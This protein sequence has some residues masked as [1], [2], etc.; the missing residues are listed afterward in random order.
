MVPPSVRASHAV[1]VLVM[2]L[3]STDTS[4]E[5]G[6]N[7]VVLNTRRSDAARCAS[8]YEPSGSTLSVLLPPT[9]CAVVSCRVIAAPLCMLRLPATPIS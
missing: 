2:L 5:R 9:V 7:V 8:R 6:P 3:K 1:L 4:N